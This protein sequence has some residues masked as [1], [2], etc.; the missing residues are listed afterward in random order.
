MMSATERKALLNGPLPVTETW[1]VWPSMPTPIIVIKIEAA[2]RHGVSSDEAVL[3]VLRTHDGD[4]GPDGEVGDLAQ[5][6]RGRAEEA[7]DGN[8]DGPDDDAGGLADILVSTS[9]NQGR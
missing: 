3:N 7:D 9:L 6:A 4:E 5:R 2:Q 8:H 1:P